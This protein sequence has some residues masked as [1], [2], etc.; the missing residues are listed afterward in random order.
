MLLYVLL[1]HTIICFHITLVDTL[2]IVYITFQSQ[3]YLSGL[4]SSSRNTNL[5]TLTDNNKKLM[6]TREE[7]QRNR[8]R[9][10]AKKKKKKISWIHVTE[11]W[12]SLSI[13]GHMPQFSSVT[14]PCPTLCDPMNSS[15]PG[16]PVHHHLLE[17]TQT[18]VHQVGDATE[19]SHPLSSPFPPAPNPSQHQ[20]LFQWV[21]SSHEVAK[22]LELQL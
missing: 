16:L 10:K 11:K 12:L 14:Q 3:T 20:S 6:K 9:A 1:S 18:Q 17:F 2:V 4:Q 8:A 5:Y 19:P 15:T 22:V 13:L 21:S 7:I